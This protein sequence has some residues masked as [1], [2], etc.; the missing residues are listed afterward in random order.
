MIKHKVC[1]ELCNDCKW[2]NH[3]ESHKHNMLKFDI[4]SKREL[5]GCE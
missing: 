5:M 3:S 1:F 2:F 4:C